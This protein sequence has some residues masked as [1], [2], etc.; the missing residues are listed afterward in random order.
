MALELLGG[1]GSGVQLGGDLGGT[2]A[3]PTVAKIQGTTIGSPPGG[4]TEYLRGDGTWAAPPTGSVT[5]GTTAGTAAQ[6]NDSRI[7][8]ASQK[9][10]NLSDLASVT[11]AVTN[12]T[13]Q[14]SGGAA[15]ALLD[16]PGSPSNPI[17]TSTA[18]R[19]TGLTVVYW[20]CATQPINWVS[21]DVWDDTTAPVSAPVIS[22]ASLPSAMVGNAYTTTLAAS[23]SPT[24]W[25]IT[26]GSAPGLSISNSGVLSGTPTTAGTDSLTFTA[27]N[28]SGTSAAVT[29]P[30]TVAAAVNLLPASVANTSTTTPWATSYGSATLSIVAN[31]TAMAA[32]VLK[33][34]FVAANYDAVADPGCIEANCAPVTAGTSYTASVELLAGSANAGIKTAVLKT[35][36]WT[37]AGALVSY[38]A[39]STSLTLSSTTPGTATETAVAPAT[40]AYAF[41]YVTF[42]EE[43]AAGDILYLAN[44]S[45]VA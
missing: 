14:A 21:G 1:G 43:T 23:N 11:T 44:P 12:L 4:T 33:T 26:S 28:A 6:G 17:T 13:L 35:E 37:S 24:S 38:S 7:V 42:D 25:A 2:T 19:P 32:H 31:E 40:A 15:L 18:A 3:A 20:Y 45:I 5:Y 29:L 39:G 10:N 8:G 30:I 16:T 27:T 9:A 36:W 41:V 22:T 34:A